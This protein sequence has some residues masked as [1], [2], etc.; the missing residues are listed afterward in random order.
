[1]WVCPRRCLAACLALL[2][3]SLQPCPS[4]PLSLP[5]HSRCLRM[6][7]SHRSVV[8]ERWKK[9]REERRAAAGRVHRDVYVDEMVRQALMAD[10]APV[11]DEGE[12][13]LLASSWLLHPWMESRPRCSVC[14]V[15]SFS[16]LCVVAATTR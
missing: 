6:R 5:A 1:V 3:V 11:P 7:L 14:E 15:L 2:P 16:L 9:E 8:A 12:A 4:L 10:A 13:A